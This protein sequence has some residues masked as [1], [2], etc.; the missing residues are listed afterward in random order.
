MFIIGFGLVL[1][2]ATLA[3]HFFLLGKRSLPYIFEAGRRKLTARQEWFEPMISR[4]QIAT[5]AATLVTSV[6]ANIRL[7]DQ[8]RPEQIRI[9]AEWAIDAVSGLS[10]LQERS[11]DMS[12]TA[13]SKD[14]L[15]AIVDDA[16]AEIDQLD[17]DGKI[18]PEEAGAAKALLAK[19]LAQTLTAAN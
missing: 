2:Q 12:S 18:K 15:E 16:N 5:D 19:A 17:S 14:L 1:G 10:S 9:L 8:S 6:R 7:V 13:T 3:L 4:D 11:S